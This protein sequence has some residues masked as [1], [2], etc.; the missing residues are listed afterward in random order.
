M[1]FEV[2]TSEAQPGIQVLKVKGEID[3]ESVGELEESAE[4]LMKVSPKAVLVDLTNVSYMGSCGIRVLL[5]LNTF[6]ARNSNKLI[7][8]GATGGVLA[9][10]ELVGFP[11]MLQ[12]TQTV[13]EALKLLSSRRSRRKVGGA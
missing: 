9:T 2:K 7:I 12:M 8:V 4:K 6:L 13:E 1:D 5:L 10:L 11:E 3:L